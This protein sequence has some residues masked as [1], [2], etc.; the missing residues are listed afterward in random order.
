EQKIAPR[1][2]NECATQA[3]IL[4]CPSKFARA[5]ITR[6]RIDSRKAIKLSRVLGAQFCH[7]IVD[8]LL[9]S[10]RNFAVGIFDECGRR[11]NYSR[12]DPCCLDRSDKRALAL[13]VVVNLLPGRPARW[14]A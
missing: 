1:T 5:L 12:R 6:E 10:R 13:Q 9:G 2:F 4:D 14:V 3:K 7:L 11:I 8:A